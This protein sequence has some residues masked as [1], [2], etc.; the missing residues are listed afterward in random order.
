MNPEIDKYVDAVQVIHARE[1]FWIFNEFGDNIYT[2]DHNKFNLDE[3]RFYQAELTGIFTWDQLFIELE[4]SLKSSRSGIEVIGVISDTAHDG[5]VG[6]LLEIVPLYHDDNV[7][8]LFMLSCGNIANFE[9]ANIISNLLFANTRR[10]LDNE[11]S[12]REL[13]IIYF[14]IRG[15]TYEQIASVLSQ[16]HNKLISSSCVGKIVR[17][18]L[19]DKFDVWNKFDLKQVLFRSNF[20]NKIPGTVCKTLLNPSVFDDELG[21]ND[22]DEVHQAESEVK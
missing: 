15:R 2:S 10:S 6:V 17:S 8:G 12:L 11:V 19:Y 14:I 20:V 5:A 4:H 18:T 13:E 1:S 16:I 22:M 21:A 7:I 9:Y 3:I